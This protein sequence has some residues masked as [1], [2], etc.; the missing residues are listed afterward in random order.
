MGHCTS[1]VIELHPSFTGHGM[2]TGNPKADMEQAIWEIVEFV[3]ISIVPVAFAPL[4]AGQ[5]SKLSE[6]Q[7][8]MVTFVILPFVEPLNLKHFWKQLIQMRKDL[9]TGTVGLKILTTIPCQFSDISTMDLCKKYQYDKHPNRQY[10]VPHIAKKWLQNIFGKLE[11]TIYTTIYISSLLRHQCRLIWRN[12]LL[13]LQLACD[14][15]GCACYL[16]NWV[17][18]KD[19]WPRQTHWSGAQMNSSP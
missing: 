7:P 9:K 12:L 3:V 15:V 11:L 5:K 8:S 4:M 1:L 14:K 16:D 19:C 13:L 10:K 17:S 2:P 18:L 6:S